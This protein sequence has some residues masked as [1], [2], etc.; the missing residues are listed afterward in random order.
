MQALQAAIFNEM[1]CSSV[2]SP[3]VLPNL[4]G[5]AW[6]LIVWRDTAPQ[7]M[8]GIISMGRPAVRR[9]R[10]NPP[11]GRDHALPDQRKR[12]RIAAAM[13]SVSLLSSVARCSA[14]IA[15]LKPVELEATKARRR[16]RRHSGRS[17]KLLSTC[18]EY[19]ASL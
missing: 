16:G 3:S 18:R 6:T 17:G 9:S 7:P 4:Y 10:L 5:L 11:G 15:S 8:L 12:L 1:V 14:S 19:R 2:Y 13:P